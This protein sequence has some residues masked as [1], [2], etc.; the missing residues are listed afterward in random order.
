MKRDVKHYLILS[1]GW[2][3]IFLGIIG[4]FLPI[5]QGILFLAIGLIILSRKSA[6][7]RL[8]NKKIG[9]RY[10]KYREVQDDASIRVKRL[11][12]KMSRKKKADTD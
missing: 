5:L 8:L 3:F 9:Q 2:I 7:V 4:L 6:R 11:I 10:P 12:E 1:L